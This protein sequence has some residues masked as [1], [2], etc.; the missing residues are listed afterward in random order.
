V[1]Q[2]GDRTLAI[3]GVDLVKI[4]HDLADAAIAEASKR[5]GIDRDAVMICPSHNHSSPFIPMGGPNNKDYISTLPGLIADSIEQ[6]Y[7][8]LQPARM[9]L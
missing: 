9:F 7:K 1:V 3:V 5:T 4:R 6:A 2:S 8:A